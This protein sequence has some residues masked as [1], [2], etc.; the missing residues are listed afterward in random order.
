MRA[1]ACPPRWPWRVGHFARRLQGAQ[2]P[3]EFLARVV[4]RVGE[5]MGNGAPIQRVSV[6][7]DFVPDRLEYVAGPVLVATVGEPGRLGYADQDV[8]G[9]WHSWPRL[10]GSREACRQTASAPPCH[11]VTS[12]HAADEALGPAPTSVH[13]VQERRLWLWLWQFSGILSS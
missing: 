1:V 10:G 7:A 5:A 11:L 6:L 13:G 8:I 12:A 4:L 2:V 3:A 9:G